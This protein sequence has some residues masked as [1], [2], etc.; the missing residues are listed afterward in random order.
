MRRSYAV[1]SH[2]LL[3]EEV[4]WGLS[5]VFQQDCKNWREQQDLQV[6]LEGSF[7]FNLRD[8]YNCLD[9]ERVGFFTR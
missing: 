1:L 2:E 8:C 5:K 7:D 9:Y 3:P 6:F 4:E